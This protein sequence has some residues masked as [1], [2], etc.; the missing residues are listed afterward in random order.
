MFA[1][2][3]FRII[4]QGALIF[5]IMGKLTAQVPAAGSFTSYDQPIPGTNIKF[6]MV[7]VKGGNFKMG[8]AQSEQGRNA[9]DGPAKQVSVSSF[10]IGA[11]EVTYDEYDAFFRD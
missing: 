8:S 11:Y 4:I 5:A 1:I 7:P 10:W 3:L 2:K 9:D 6:K